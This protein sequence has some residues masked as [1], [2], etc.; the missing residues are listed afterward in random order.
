MGGGCSVEDWKDDNGF[1]IQTKEGNLLEGLDSQML[2]RSWDPL[3]LWSWGILGVKSLNQ[4]G[5]M[6]KHLNWRL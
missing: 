6:M 5:T 3:R 4:A 2:N 1:K